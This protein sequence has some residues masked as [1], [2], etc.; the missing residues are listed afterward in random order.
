MCQHT[1]CVSPCVPSLPLP[2]LCTRRSAAGTMWLLLTILSC[3]AAVTPTP[4]Q[5]PQALPQC[6]GAPP[7]HTHT[8]TYSPPPHPPNTTTTLTNPTPQHTASQ[9]QCTSHPCVCVLPLQRAG[10]VLLPPTTSSYRT[11][12]QSKQSSVAQRPPAF[13]KSASQWRMCRTCAIALNGARRSCLIPRMA[14]PI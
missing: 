14:A 12:A 4:H 11:P 6:P 3:V 7:P 1:P 13:A 8:H 9:A 5:A 10:T 2:P